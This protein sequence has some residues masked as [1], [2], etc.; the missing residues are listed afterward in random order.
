MLGI[1]D[2]LDGIIS[3][4]KNGFEV[5]GYF[6]TDMLPDFIMN[7]GYQT[8]NLPPFI[9]GIFTV[10]VNLMAIFMFFKLLKLFI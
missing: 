6:L 7:A 2:F 10:T 3:F 4:I 8:S 9:Q 5:L 1:L